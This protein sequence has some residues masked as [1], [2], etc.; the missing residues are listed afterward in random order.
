MAGIPVPGD[1]QRADRLDPTWF[2]RSAPR[3]AQAAI[4]DCWATG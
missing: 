4:A 1:I 2:V 3:L